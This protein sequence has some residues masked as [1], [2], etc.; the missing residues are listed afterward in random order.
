MNNAFNI[1]IDGNYS[2]YAS[3]TPT[4]SRA[5]DDV[6][7]LATGLDT[8]AYHTYT[9]QAATTAQY[10][11]Q[12]LLDP[13]DVIDTTPE[14]VRKR[15]MFVGDSI[16]SGVGS[17]AVY[18]P[19]LSFPWRI[20]QYLGYSCA[21]ESMSGVTLNGS[22]APFS[23]SLE[24]ST[25]IN[26]FVDAYGTNDAYQGLSLSGFQT[27]EETIVN[28]VL[29]YLSS[30]GK[31]YS[32]DIFPAQTTWISTSTR[33]TYDTAKRAGV[34]AVASS[35]VAS[36]QTNTALDAYATNA[37]PHPDD[38]GVSQIVSEL[39]ADLSPT[40][41]TVT[42][43]SSGTEGQTS[44]A[45]TI[46]FA[47]GAYF[48]GL[49]SITLSDSGAGGTFTPSVGSTTTGS[50]T[51]TPT[52]SST[53]FTFTY[54]PATSGAIT[55]AFSNGQGWTDPSAI[56]YTAKS[57][58]SSSSTSTAAPGSLT[59]TGG[60]TRYGCTDSSATN[61]QPGSASD[62]SLC[63]YGISPPTITT[64]RK[65]LATSSNIATAPTGQPVAAVPRPRTGA[66]RRAAATP[67]A[68]VAAIPNR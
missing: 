66:K 22:T 51:V 52:A 37:S 21:R 40:G 28:N 20:C 55:L 42:G 63:T 53:A 32:L 54:T 34:T 14:P 17:S 56:T 59:A 43:P 26:A 3:V 36:Y 39:V 47:S 10:L 46:T 68:S 45:F 9:I 62:S 67:P 2:S 29:P 4:V 60:S 25:T 49:Q 8:T 58:A 6:L 1:I 41:Y 57:P 48:N 5:G 35:Q 16:T 11:T 12:L 65:S 15:A 7:T 24:A 38:L 19:F 31:Y 27:N 30:S 61:Y 18:N 33:N 13:G 44:N 23:G 50:V 64:P